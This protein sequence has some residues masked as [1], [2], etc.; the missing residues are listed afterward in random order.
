VRAS[1]EAGREHRKASDYPFLWQRVQV[2]PHYPAFCLR[3][4]SY[5]VR[6][7]EHADEDD[8]GG[9]MAWEVWHWPS[10]TV[11]SDWFMLSDAIKA[12]RE[13]YAA[14]RWPD[15]ADTTFVP[16]KATP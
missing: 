16:R 10:N 3:H 11:E 13:L 6:L 5:G 15:P 9:H 12:C 8:R 2:C 1:C 4:G 14:E 7:N